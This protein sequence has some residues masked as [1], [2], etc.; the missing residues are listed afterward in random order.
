MFYKPSPEQRE[1]YKDLSICILAPCGGY[2]SPVRFMRS[3]VNMVAYS[4]M[5]GLKVYQ[6]GNTERTVVD[7]ARNDLARIAKTKV[8]EYTGEKFTHL[9]WL[10][11]DHVFNPDL[12]LWL[13]QN[14]DK[15]MISA[16]YYGR[17]DQILPVVYA[18]GEKEEGEFQHH[19]II[20]IPSEICEVDAVGFGTLLMRRDVLDRVPEPWFTL[21]WRSGEDIAFC[22]AA[23]KH[24]VQIFL[25]GRYKIGHMGPRPIVTEKDYIKYMDD[26]PEIRETKYRVDLSEKRRN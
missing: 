18:K 24:G 15:D 26:H 4:W 6:M 13:V 5:H 2:E 14:A 7:W 16:L 25:D 22:V 19:A 21:D 17:C 20:D 3:V 12:A 1:A 23:K 8:N 10:D 11:D 9:L